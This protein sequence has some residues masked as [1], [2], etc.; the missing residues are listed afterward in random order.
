MNNKQILGIFA[1]SMI[2]IFLVS[3][4][5]GAF[6]FK[7]NYF[8]D[9]T[10]EEKAEIKETKES[11]ESA[12]ESNDYSAWKSLM[13]TQLTQER[14]DKLVEKQNDMS[15]LKDLKN[16]LK[17]AFKDEDQEKIDELKEELSELRPNKNRNF[18]LEDKP[19]FDKNRYSKHKGFW[20][21]FQFWKN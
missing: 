9:L 5:V 11:I 19:Q 16:Q 15:E 12:I 7:G 3:S 1:I 2:S 8:N 14:F 20:K 6:P 4:F 13:E 10:D 18:N 17:Q 21:K